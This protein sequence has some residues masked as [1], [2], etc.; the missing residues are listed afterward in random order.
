VGVSV[1]VAVGQGRPSGSSVGHG[2]GVGSAE[3]LS[4]EREAS[5]T[6]SAVATATGRAKA[7]AKA[8]MVKYLVVMSCERIRETSEEASPTYPQVVGVGSST[9]ESSRGTRAHSTLTSWAVG[10][11]AGPPL[12]RRKP[13][14]PNCRTRNR[15]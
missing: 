10:V 2:V 8:T 6:T 11:T 1:G 15:R 13:R 5:P 7:A 14:Q 12:I 4:E 9:I 3:A